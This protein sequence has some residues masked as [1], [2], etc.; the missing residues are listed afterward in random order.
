MRRSLAPWLA[1]GAILVAGWAFA[2]PALGGDRVS[3]APD[4]LPDEMGDPNK[5]PDMDHGD[6]RHHHHQHLSDHRGH[7]HKPSGLGEHHHHH[8]S[9]PH[10]PDPHHHHPH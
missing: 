5:E 6:K 7:E 9:H 8:H 10:A 2:P 4:Y 1:A 3:P